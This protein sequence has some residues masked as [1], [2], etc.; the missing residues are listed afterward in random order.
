MPSAGDIKSFV[1]NLLELSARRR[2][3]L[4]SLVLS[5]RPT[6]A[7][8]VR[9]LDP[10]GVPA[11]VWVNSPLPL[12]PC[13]FPLTVEGSEPAGVDLRSASTHR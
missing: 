6:A 5:A 12:L 8:P 4:L 10:T 2:F 11:R 13:G 1:L 7:S 3:R 9:S